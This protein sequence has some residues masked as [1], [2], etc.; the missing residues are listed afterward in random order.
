[1]G[2]AVTAGVAQRGTMSLARKY[3]VLVIGMSGTK[4]HVFKPVCEISMGLRERGIE[5]SVMILTTGEGVPEDTPGTLAIKANVMRLTP[6]EVEQMKPAKVV[7]AHFGNVR[8]HVIYKARMLLR[9]AENPFVIVCQAPLDFEDFARIGVLT[10]YVR[11]LKEKVGTKGHIAGIVT[12]VTRGVTCPESKIDEIA[13]AVWATMPPPYIEPS[14]QL[15]VG[16]TARYMPTG[17][18]G[19]IEAVESDENGSWAKF[20]GIDLWY[21]TSKLQYE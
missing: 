19:V 4:R 8:T 2:V 11:P 6:R 16:R 18:K 14:P 20:E 21:H 9:N 13:R 5:L 7:I 3:D 15:E 1:M 12:D 10:K 17:T